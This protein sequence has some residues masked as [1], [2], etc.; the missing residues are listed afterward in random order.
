MF[1]IMNCLNGFFQ[2][3][4][5]QSLAESL[6]LAPNGGAVAVWASSGLT[7]PAPQFAMNQKFVQTLFSKTE[8][9]IG[10][11]VLAA[12]S[13]VADD[14]VRKTFILFGDPAMRLQIP[15]SSKEKTNRD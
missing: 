6:L 11:A 9:A 5:T 1:V 4:Y 7:Q 13:A 12:K 3:V 10:D 15:G 8:P 2:D 14:D